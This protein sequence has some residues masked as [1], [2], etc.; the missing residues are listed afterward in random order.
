MAV[1]NVTA[2]AEADCRDALG[3][4]MSDF[5][6]AVAAICAKKIGADCIVS[7]NRKLISANTG[8]EGIKP[9]QPPA[10]VK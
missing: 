5:E 6:D 8:V 9:G 10:G 3:F 4:P 2:P 1:V 7:R